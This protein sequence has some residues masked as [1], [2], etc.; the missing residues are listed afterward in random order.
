M[1]VQALGRPADYH[2]LPQELPPAVESSVLERTQ[3]LAVT[4]TQTIRPEMTM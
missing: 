2:V 1:D 4:T 3:D